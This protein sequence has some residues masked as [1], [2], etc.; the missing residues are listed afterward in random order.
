M[1]QAAFR[2]GQGAH[3]LVALKM[4]Q[5]R[6]PRVVLAW[7]PEGTIHK[8]GIARRNRL[9]ARRHDKVLLR[10]ATRRR[11][12]N[13]RESVRLVALRS[14]PRRAR[15]RIR[16]RHVAERAE[17]RGK[18]RGASA[19]APVQGACAATRLR[20]APRAFHSESGSA[21]CLVGTRTRPCTT[22]RLASRQHSGCARP[23][24]VRCDRSHRLKSDRIFSN[25]PS[26]N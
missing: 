24:Q 17:R 10:A 21:P 19:H 2:H 4:A 9:R 20:L 7:L 8:V 11:R 26:S 23:R 25:A 5:V 16:T 6:V 13:P 15:R 1:P 3:P 14:K 18:V 12:N 22:C